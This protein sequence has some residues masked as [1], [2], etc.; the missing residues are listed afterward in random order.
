[1]SDNIPATHRIRLA[2]PWIVKSELD[3]RGQSIKTKNGCKVNLPA[4]WQN[5]FGLQNGTAVFKRSFNSPTGLH[6]QKIFLVLPLTNGSGQLHL[7]D[8]FLGEFNEETAEGKADADYEKKYEVSQFLQLHNQLKIELTCQPNTAHKCGL[9]NA[10]VL[11]IVEDGTV[12][13]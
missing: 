2:G 7:N 11:E 12:P 9:C 13:K 5:I 4:S 8:Q 3:F 10:I 6:G 1:M